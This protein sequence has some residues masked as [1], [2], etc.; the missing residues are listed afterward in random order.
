VGGGAGAGD[1]GSGAGH[2][3]DPRAGNQG[4]DKDLSHIR[5]SN[6]G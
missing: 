4:D 2:S 6:I 5:G 3:T 1:L